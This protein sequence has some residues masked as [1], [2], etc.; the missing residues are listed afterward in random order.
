[1]LL[2][3]TFVFFCPA[4]SLRAQMV[5]AAQWHLVYTQIRDCLIPKQEAQLRLKCLEVMLKDLYLKRSNQK[6]KSTLCFPLEGYTRSAIGGEKGS[7][8]HARGY[9]FFD[10][11]RHRGHPGHDIFIRDRDQDGIDDSTGKS[12]NVISA[13]SGIIVSVNPDWEPSSP[14]RGGNT[15]WIYEPIKSRYYY[16]AHL[17]EIFVET[18][19]TVSRGERIGTVGRT[20]KNAYPMQS[21]THLHFTVHRS[22]EGCPVPVDPYRELVKGGCGLKKSLLKKSLDI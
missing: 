2:V 22:T 19:Q 9:D 17:K 5:P 20:G 12:V 13:S 8:Y 10:G 14:I 4:E 1:M 16:Y 6:E 11:D 21:P 3:L 7:G 15:I 18:G